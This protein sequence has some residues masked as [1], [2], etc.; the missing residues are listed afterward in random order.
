MTREPGESGLVLL[1][2]RPEELRRTS[3][4]RPLLRRLLRRPGSYVR[5]SGARV[6]MALRLG[7][8]RGECTATIRRIAPSPDF[9]PLLGRRAVCPV[10]AILERPR[11]RGRSAERVHRERLLHRERLEVREARGQ[12]SGIA[13]IAPSSPVSTC[14]ALHEE[15]GADARGRSPSGRRAMSRSKRP[16]QKFVLFAGERHVQTASAGQASGTVGRDG[17]LVEVG[18]LGAER[19]LEVE[20]RRPDPATRIVVSIPSALHASRRKAAT[21]P[22]PGTSTWRSVMRRFTVAAR[23]SS[24]RAAA[25][26]PPG[27]S[28]GEAPGVA[29]LER[30]ARREAKRTAGM[31]AVLRDVLDERLAVDRERH[32]PALVD[33]ADRRE[34]EGV[35]R[36]LERRVGLELAPLA[37]RGQIRLREAASRR[38]PRRVPRRTPAASRRRPR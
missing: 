32:R 35:E 17:D 8:A 5:V 2:A 30:R 26:S 33:V 23:S 3:G 28:Q 16:L 29:A 7:S 19:P 25:R 9:R 37:Q 1:E 36:G 31:L 11:G 15:V 14:S 4:R 20:V 22:A 6:A 34:V 21:S 12:R 10:S 27:G 38:A 18:A 13:G 24:S